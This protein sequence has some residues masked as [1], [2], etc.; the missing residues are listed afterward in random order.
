[1][2][3]KQSNWGGFW[4]PFEIAIVIFVFVSFTKIPTETIFTG[5]SSLSSD[6]P[7]TPTESNHSIKI[8]FTIEHYSGFGNLA[9]ISDTLAA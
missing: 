1:M 7:S 6:Q 3:N 8:A 5:S 9:F 2:D 4:F